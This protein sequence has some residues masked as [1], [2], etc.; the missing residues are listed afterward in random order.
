MFNLKIKKNETMFVKE[1][2]IYLL[3]VDGRF[4]LSYSCICK[5]RF[6]FFRWNNE[7]VT[8]RNFPLLHCSMHL[9]KPCFLF[10]CKTFLF[11]ETFGLR[12]IKLR[13][14]SELNIV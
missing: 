11:K 10:N 9:W 5:K 8:R 4:T 12:F 1:P 3:N 7:A 14:Q 2:S 13:F 6:L